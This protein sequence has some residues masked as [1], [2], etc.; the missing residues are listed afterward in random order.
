VKITYLRSVHP[1]C[2][3]KKDHEQKNILWTKG[4]FTCNAWQRVQ[5]GIYCLSKTGIYNL[6]C[7]RW[8]EFTVTVL[9][10][11]ALQSW[12]WYVTQQ[13][14]Q[15]TLLCFYCQMVKRTCQNVTLYAHC[16]T[17]YAIPRMS[18]LNK[19]LLKLLG[20]GRTPSFQ[21]IKYSLKEETG[22]RTTLR[23]KNTGTCLKIRIV[24]S[25]L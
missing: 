14:T 4:T 2:T 8:R 10:L 5:I 19:G 6:H 9:T 21:R 18:Y 13:Q 1:N 20:C 25:F 15:H 3:Y 16:I 12:Q 17:P 24:L 22:L 11:N 7:C 23:L